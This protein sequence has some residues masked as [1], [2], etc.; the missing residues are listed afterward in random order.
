MAAS[1]RPPWKRPN[2]R[3]KSGAARKLTPA[4][5]RHAEKAARKAGRRYPNL[6]DNMR[7]AVRARKKSAARKSP[8]KKKRQGQ[9]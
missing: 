6:V 3:K 7:E 1:R 4:Q 9:G 2:P 8:A 5:K